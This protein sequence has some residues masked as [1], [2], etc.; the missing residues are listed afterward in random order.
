MSE[1][2]KVMVVSNRGSLDTTC[3]SSVSPDLICVDEPSESNWIP[4]PPQIP[5][6]SLE[7]LPRVV[8]VELELADEVMGA[9][10]GPDLL[11]PR[12]GK[13]VHIGLGI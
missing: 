4:L 6:R 5:R 12:S 7:F 1:S 8:S 11:K 10:P 9:V 2:E 13:D 3:I